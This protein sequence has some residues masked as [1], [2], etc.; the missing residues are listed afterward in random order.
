MLDGADWE[1]HRKTATK[2][3]AEKKT[4]SVRWNWE[5][6]EKEKKGLKSKIIVHLVA[7]LLIQSFPVALILVYTQHVTIKVH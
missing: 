4:T 6:N 1:H 7:Y 2:I 3:R 5:E